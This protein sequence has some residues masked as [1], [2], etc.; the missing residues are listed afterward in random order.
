VA[1]GAHGLTHRALT[2]LKEVEL[3][4]EVREPAERIEAETGV[5]PRTFAYPYGAWDARTARAVAAT[6]DLAC[7]TELRVFRAGEARH[8]LPR[9]DMWYFRRHGRLEA[10]GKRSFRRYL[11]LRN[12][13]RS[14]RRLISKGNGF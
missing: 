7:T 5:R 2:G 9:L 3:E 8:A 10:W 11:L 13:L 4:R 6:Y 1:L 14:A 12:R